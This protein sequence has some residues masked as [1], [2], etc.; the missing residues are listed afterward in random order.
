[1]CDHHYGCQQW[2]AGGGRGSC[3]NA[4]DSVGRGRAL[5]N[6]RVPAGSQTERIHRHRASNGR[7]SRCEMPPN[8]WKRLIADVTPPCSGIHVASQLMAWAVPG[9]RIILTAGHPSEM[10]SEQQRAA[11]AEIPSDSVRVLWKPFYPGELIGMVEE[12]IGSANGDPHGS[13]VT[14]LKITPGPPA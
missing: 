7:N 13:S 12:L 1:M 14:V 8:W 9:L 10:S 6:E 2:L 11:L 3:T 4:N 5:C